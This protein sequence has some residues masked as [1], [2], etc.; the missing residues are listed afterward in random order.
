MANNIYT[1]TGQH[2]IYTYMRTLIAHT[3]IIVI[4]KYNVQCTYYIYIYIY[5]YPQCNEKVNRMRTSIYSRF[6]DSFDF[7]DSSF[8][9]VTIAYYSMFG[10]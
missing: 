2:P 4:K 8:G 6:N 9:Q 3:I 7:W 10:K 1:G 5:T